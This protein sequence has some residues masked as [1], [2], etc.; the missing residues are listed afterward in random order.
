MPV[1]YRGPRALITHRVIEV[2]SRERQAFTLR[3]LSR[4]QAVQEGPDLSANRF[5][6]VGV[7]AVFTMVWAVP[8]LGRTS[9]LLAGVV[10]LALVVCAGAC[11]RV[12]PRSEYRLLALN[13]GE[14]VILVET[15]DRQ[16]FDQIVRGLIRALDYRGDSK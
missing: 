4:I 1:F 12:R 7:T 15:D 9:M 6:A 13:E 5:R 11:L 3:E 10:T 8:M 2:P 14:L 16:E